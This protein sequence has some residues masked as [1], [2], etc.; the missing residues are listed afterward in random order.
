MRAKGIMWLFGAGAS[1]TAGIATAWDMLW[2]FKRSLYCSLEKIS[3][4]SCGD[5]SDEKVQYRI[6]SYLEAHLAGCPKPGAEDEYAFFFE[7][8]YASDKDRRTYIETKVKTGT[9]S[10]GHECLGILMHMGLV[11]LIWTTNFDRVIEDVAVKALGG[12]GKI[13]IAA[14]E[15]AQL[16]IQAVNE[17]RWPVYF[18]IH[19]DFQSRKLK[20][21]G[22]ELLTQDENMRQSLIDCSRRF[23]LAVVGYSGR[24]DSV[25]DALEKSLSKGAF[26]EGLFWFRRNAKSTYPRVS[27]FIEKAKSLGIEADFVEAE[28]FDELFN[29]IVTQIPDIPDGTLQTLRAQKPK[30]T[31]APM[32]G[33]G[34]LGSYPVLRL[35]AIPVIEYPSV[36]RL[37]ECGI[38][39]TKEV[40]EALTAIGSKAIAVR[41]KPGVLCFGSDAEL[42]QAFAKYRIANFDVKQIDADRLKFHSAE[43][44]LLYDAIIAAILRSRPLVTDHKRGT[45]L[46]YI[47]KARQLEPA[48][49][50]LKDCVRNLTGTVGGVNWA[51]GIRLKLDYKF[52][53]LWLLFEPAIW[54]ADESLKEFVRKRMASRY[55]QDWNGLLASW[56][57]ILAG[58]DGSDPL[59]A[60]GIGDGLDA[61]FRL[62]AT[63]A[64]SRI[65]K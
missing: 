11:R 38:G 63:T 54:I 59:R 1:A 20:N 48:L 13:V 64:F 53:K 5:L 31:E 3:P 35:N 42:K 55:N 14:L 41:S 8:A 52:G 15:N 27:D 36:M 57:R 9:P 47:N 44:G 30:L 60:L 49:I 19:G 12:T 45:R 23:G 26:P 4:K 29:D 50:P 24:D 37:I 46:L 62:D 33:A 18:K 21:I 25:M 2:D 58:P 51:E 17:D 34:T 10:F 39:G 28:S 7:Q 61:V 40:N 43:F 32:A 56:S 65:A 6:Q 16:G 22:S